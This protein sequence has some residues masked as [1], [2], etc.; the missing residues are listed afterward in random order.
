MKLSHLL[1]TTSL[2]AVAAM[3]AFAQARSFSEVDQNDD[4]FLSEVEL[5]AAFGASGAS[6]IILR[7]DMDEDG[8]VSIAEIKI[9][10]DD[11][12]SDDEDDDEPDDDD[13]DESD[14]EDDDEPDDD[15]SDES[16]DEDDST[17]SDEG[18]DSDEDDV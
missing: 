4:G 11:D 18:D 2:C 9:S 10:H 1:L 12:E 5:V 7:S 8:S 3:P 14:D 6:S 15:D 13:S 17:D 16:D